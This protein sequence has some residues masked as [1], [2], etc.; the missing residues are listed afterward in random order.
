MLRTGKGIIRSS[1]NKAGEPNMG[2]V[3]F[4]LCMMIIHPTKI[5]QKNIFI[6]KDNVHYRVFSLVHQHLILLR[7]LYRAETYLKE[8]HQ[9]DPRLF[10]AFPLGNPHFEQVELEISSVFD[11]IIFQLS[12]VFDYISHLICYICKKDKSKT[13]YWTKLVSSAYGQNKR[14]NYFSRIIT[15][16]RSWQGQIKAT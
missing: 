9:K 11:S 13:L 16:V 12:S 6:V 15:P 2:F 5:P 14:L 10:N 8:L 7:E 3:P 1:A 4:V